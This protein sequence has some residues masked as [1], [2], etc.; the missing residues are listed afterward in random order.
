LNLDI[1]EDLFLNQKTSQT[2]ITDI[3]GKITRGKTP[4][5]FRTLTHDPTREIV[6]LMGPDGLEHIL[7]KTGSESLV[8]IGYTQDHIHHLLDQGF[9]FKLIIFNPIRSCLLAT[10]DN[11]AKLASEVYPK[12]KK[13]IYNKIEEIK[14]IFFEEIEKESSMIWGEIDKAGPSNPNFM[15][16]KRFKQSK[17]TLLDVRA[18]FYF[19][20]HFRELFSGDGYTYN[21]KGEKTLKE[22]ICVNQKLKNFKDYRLIDVKI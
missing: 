12:V 2:P 11:A 19:T 8:E 5:E 6:M 3:M 7:G 15:T 4:K 18:F 13:K 16:Y 20:L 10:W 14:E 17:G 9:K 22:Y 1:Y 21:Q